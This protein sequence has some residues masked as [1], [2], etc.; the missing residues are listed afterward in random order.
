[1]FWCRC[2]GGRHASSDAYFIPFTSATAHCIVAA[3]IR[4]PLRHADELVL[5]RVLQNM[6]LGRKVEPACFLS[7]ARNEVG[8]RCSRCTCRAALHYMNVHV[9]EAKK[10]RLVSFWVRSSSCRVRARS[11]DE[12]SSFV[13]QSSNVKSIDAY[14]MFHVQN[15]VEL[16]DLWR[17]CRGQGLEGPYTELANW[18][19][20]FSCP[21]S[22]KGLLGQPSHKALSKA[23][24][25]NQV[26]CALDPAPLRPP[27]SQVGGPQL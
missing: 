9:Q 21:C 27:T 2:R 22:C 15:A 6:T 20:F 16:L 1:M 4:P 23:P 25:I 7:N 12:S 13:E 17:I 24:C 18:R 3:V 5:S 11:K 14:V 26:A 10:R 8:D 19:S